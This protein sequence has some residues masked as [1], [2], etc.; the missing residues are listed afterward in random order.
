MAIFISYLAFGIA[1]REILAG[2]IDQVGSVLKLVLNALTAVVCLVLAVL[3]LSDYRKARRGKVRQMTL[4]L[5]DKLRR[6]INAT[7]RKGMQSDTL[8]RLRT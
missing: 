5:P 2:L 3:S 1:L 6:W 8:G 7:V 4:R